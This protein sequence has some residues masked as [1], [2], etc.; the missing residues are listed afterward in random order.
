[1]GESPGRS[2]I[3]RQP[4]WD[5]DKDRLAFPSWALAQGSSRDSPGVVSGVGPS[6]QLYISALTFSLQLLITVSRRAKR[7][8]VS[9]L[10]DRR[11]SHLLVGD[12]LA[13]THT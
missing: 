11:C 9:F 6:C 10:L 13:H 8:P 12:L 7:V 2:L 1:M 4:S 5:E 3:L